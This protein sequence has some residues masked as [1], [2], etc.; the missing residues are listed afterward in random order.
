MTRQKQQDRVY[1]RGAYGVTGTAK[2]SFDAIM[3]T[4]GVPVTQETRHTGRTV[5]CLSAWSA[6]AKII[7]LG[8]VIAGAL[9]RASIPATDID[10]TLFCCTLPMTHF[11][12][13]RSIVRSAL[14]RVGIA[15]PCLHLG[16]HQCSGTIAAIRQAAR[17]LHIR[18]YRH[19]LV[20]TVDVVDF[21]THR[22]LDDGV[23]QGDAAAAL[24]ISRTPGDIECLGTHIVT[25]PSRYDM[26]GAA[27]NDGW[28]YFFT[29]RSLVQYML[30]NHRIDIEQV[31]YL[32]PHLSNPATWRHISEFL[33]FRGKLLLQ[34]EMSTMGHLFG[35]DCVL[36]LMQLSLLRPPKGAYALALTYGMGASW[37]GLLVQT[38]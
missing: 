4:E 19:I 2:R 29:L 31:A 7:L 36:G 30:A 14:Q 38:Q 5:A 6:D 24:I 23:V 32:I 16:G 28:R 33:R 26:S 35:T 18:P 34:H 1:V 20:A 9:K 17:W 27:N 25:D 11:P 37:G 15:G 10:A 8:C 22:T 12:A 21:T 13:G 3:H